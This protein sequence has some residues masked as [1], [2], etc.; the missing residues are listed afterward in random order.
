VSRRQVLE[1]SIAESYDL[2]GQYEAIERTSDDPKEKLRARRNID[3]Q[4]ALIKGYQAELETLTG[5]GKPREEQTQHPQ[6][7]A[8]NSVPS[9]PITHIHTGGGMYVAGNITNEGVIV[10]RDQQVDG[11]A[12]SGDK[13]GGDKVGGDKSSS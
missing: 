7:E 11:D 12:V 4:Q 1:Q 8:S 9:A 2:I 5:E 6:S 13:V 10:G 3:E